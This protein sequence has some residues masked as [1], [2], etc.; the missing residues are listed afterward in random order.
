[1]KTKYLKL[2][3]ILDLEKWQI[4]QDSLA[5]ATKLAII[6][7]DHKGTPITIH[8]NPR[9][10]CEHIRGDANMVKFCQKCDSRAGLEAVRA[11]APYIY[12]CHCKIVDVAIPISIDDNYIGAIM[13]GQ[14][15][16]PENEDSEVLEQILVSP[17]T[18]SS[19][20]AELQ[21]MY[22]EIPEIPYKEIE[23]VARMLFDLCYYIIEESINKNFILDVYEGTLSS[24]QNP[25]LPAS[26]SDGYSPANIAYLKNEFGNITANTYVKTNNDIQLLCKNP[27]LKPAFEYIRI[28]KGINITQKKMS[29]LCHISTG[30]FSRLFAKETGENFSSFLARQRVEWSKRLLTETDLSINQ[31][32]DELGFNDAGYYIKIFKKYESI[33]PATYRKY[34]STN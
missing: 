23:K 1:M 12:L 17:A 29:E 11:N 10:F 20:S 31:I 14:V 6:T 32:S 33:T 4:L 18:N 26:F 19:F 3:K 21:G 16:L 13:A 24:G 7:V 25:A 2:N 22:E 8:S 34:H 28:N 5:L 15:K 9:P 30:H 27:I